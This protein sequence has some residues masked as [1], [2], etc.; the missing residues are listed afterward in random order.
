MDTG[1]TFTKSGNT[2]K[3]VHVTDDVVDFVDGITGPVW[4]QNSRAGVIEILQGGKA[5][6]TVAPSDI[7]TIDGDAPE[8]AIED[9]ID[10]LIAV[11]P[12][13]SS[14][15]GSTGG[16][17]EETDFVTSSGSTTITLTKTYIPGSPKVYMNG[18]RLKPSLVTE[19]TA[20]T[21]TLGVTPISGD[22]LI[23]DFKH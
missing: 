7:L 2:T 3:I 22:E 10:Q 8:S 1:Y 5:V 6:Q 11:F 23:I 12:E 17:T 14:G 19:A 16:G 20:T 13:A 18:V 4:I 9:L 21:L 15:S